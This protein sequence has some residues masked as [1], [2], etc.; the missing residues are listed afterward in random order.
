M[1]NTSRA[2][3]ASPQASL[4]AVLLFS[5]LLR[6]VERALARRSVCGDEGLMARE[7]PVQVFG[8]I[9]PR[10]DAL[11]QHRVGVR[12]GA[13]VARQH[14]M[15]HMSRINHSGGSTTSGV[16]EMETLSAASIMASASPRLPQ[17]HATAL[18]HR[19]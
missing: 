19:R 6:H 7:D 10:R 2:V 8:I 14:H 3:S 9:G 4:G 18:Q 16:D 11:L 1:R 15:R 13:V 17:D 12:G 5:A